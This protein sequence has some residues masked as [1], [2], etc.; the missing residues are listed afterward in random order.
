MQLNNDESDPHNYTLSLYYPPFRVRW[1]KVKF[2]STNLIV[3]EY[4]SSKMVQ[5]LEHAARAG[6]PLMITVSLKPH[7]I[8]IAATIT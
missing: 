5:F 1:L 4:G 6:I 2:A 7:Y 3:L 8:I